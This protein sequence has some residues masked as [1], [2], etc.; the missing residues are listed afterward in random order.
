MA[1]S[2][3]SP[4]KKRGNYSIQLNPKASYFLQDWGMTVISEYAIS[5]KYFFVRDRHVQTDLFP[6]HFHFLFPDLP[7]VKDLSSWKD[8][9]LLSVTP[10]KKRPSLIT[11]VW[12]KE[13][14]QKL[15]NKKIRITFR[16]KE[17]EIYILKSFLNIQR[18]FSY[19]SFRIVPVW[20]VWIL[21]CLNTSI[22]RQKN[23]TDVCKVH[24]PIRKA[25][26]APSF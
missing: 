13:L 7:P 8:L 14:N 21:L 5:H 26:A 24:K 11:A 16:Q 6:K 25:E 20:L 9:M 18:A 3:N 15:G 17:L 2:S 10:P 22:K 4:S 23:D 1:L 12:V 19:N